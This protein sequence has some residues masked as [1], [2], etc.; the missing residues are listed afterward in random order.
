[1][2]EHTPPTAEQTHE[3]AAQ[4]PPRRS[5]LAKIKLPAAVLAVVLVECGITYLWLPG[6]SE[7]E[8][9]AAV[10][11]TMAAEEQAAED[12]E[13]KETAQIEADLG[14]FTV[15]AYQ[16]VS[17]ATMRIDFHLYAMIGQHENEEF[18]VLK[19]ECQARLREQVTVI[20]RGAN[21]TDLTDPGLGLIK[22]QI[23]EKIN[24][25]LGKPLVQSV[26]FSDFSFIEQ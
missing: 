6:V 17:N 23:L 19:E 11:A 24:R 5:L 26:V 9:R 4:S 7:A 20:V 3:T 8:A 12:E 1:M 2:A 13:Q 22:R 18:L 25:I 10:E 21:I 14:A 15:M 16:P